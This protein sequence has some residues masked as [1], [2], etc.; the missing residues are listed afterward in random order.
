MLVVG[1]VVIGVVV[2][3]SGVAGDENRERSEKR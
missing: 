3:L 2:T 1:G